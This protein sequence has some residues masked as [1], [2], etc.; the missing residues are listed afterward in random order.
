MRYAFSGL[1]VTLETLTKKWLRFHA[2]V[3]LLSDYQ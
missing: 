2:L 3:K 1:G